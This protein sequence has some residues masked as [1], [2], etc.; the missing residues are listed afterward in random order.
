MKPAKE[1]MFEFIK[2]AYSGNKVN[3]VIK[4]EFK[5]FCVNI[6]ENMNMLQ[7]CYSTLTEEQKDEIVKRAKVNNNSLSDYL[8]FDIIVGKP[9]TDFNNIDI[10]SINESQKSELKNLFNNF[11]PA[12]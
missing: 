10:N 6:S 4:D 5:I 12:L 7:E 1:I 9:I 2:K 8:F 3:E 11:I